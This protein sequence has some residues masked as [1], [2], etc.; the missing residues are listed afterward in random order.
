[1][2]KSLSLNP[3]KIKMCKCEQCNY[4]KKQR[5]NRK[6]IKYMKRL[7]NKRIRNSKHDNTSY[8]HYFS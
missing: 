2:P 5:S 3:I 7:F 4:I 8:T 1:M 6:Y